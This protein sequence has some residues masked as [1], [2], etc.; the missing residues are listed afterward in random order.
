MIFFSRDVN[1]NMFSSLQRGPAVQ[2]T[3][4]Y[5]YVCVFLF[6]GG[7]MWGGRG[8]CTVQYGSFMSFKLVE[9]E[10]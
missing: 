7:G 4:D 5:L 6:Q 3:T 1:V 9:Q 2:Y 10:C 8:S